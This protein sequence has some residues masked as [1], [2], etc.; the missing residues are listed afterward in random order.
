MHFGWMQ[1][2][3]HQNDASMMGAGMMQHVNIASEEEFIKNMIP[4]HQEAVDTSTRL[5]QMGQNPELKQLA[6]NIVSA[7]EDEIAMMNGWVQKR[8]ATGTVQAN[9][10]PMMRDTSTLSAITTIEK[11]RLED[12]IQHHM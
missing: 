9:Y 8:Y 6:A 7:Q 2:M 11:M 12:M 4:H 10:Q 5:A 3:M 1:G